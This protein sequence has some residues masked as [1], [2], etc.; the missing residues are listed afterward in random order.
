VVKDEL[1]AANP[2]LAKEV[3]DAFAEAKRL[4][5]KRLRDGAIEKPTARTPLAFR[6]AR[7]SN[8]ILL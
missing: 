1:L 8:E 3:F 5:V 2:G 7:R 4:Y 6:N